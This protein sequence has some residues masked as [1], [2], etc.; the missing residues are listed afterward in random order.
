MSPSSPGTGRGQTEISRSQKQQIQQLWLLQETQI[1]TG[2]ISLGLY[3][4]T[5]SKSYYALSGGQGL[6]S[7]GAGEM[8]PWPPGRQ[9]PPSP[10]LTLLGPS[11]PCPRKTRTDPVLAVHGSQR[12]KTPPETERGLDPAGKAV[13]GAEGFQRL[14]PPSLPTTGLCCF[15]IFVTITYLW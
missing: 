12:T 7:S 14:K 15:I 11:P 2:L 4:H 5:K 8:I 10:T 1:C 3:R 6:T 13:M 9:T